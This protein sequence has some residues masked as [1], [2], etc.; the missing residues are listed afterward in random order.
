MNMSRIPK[1]SNK[2]LHKLG[3]KHNSVFFNSSSFESAVIAAGST[4][5]VMPYIYWLV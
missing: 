1:L 2:D 5:Q 4:L 3:Y